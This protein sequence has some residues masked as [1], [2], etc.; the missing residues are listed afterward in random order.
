[1]VSNKVL[2]W[3]D[4]EVVASMSNPERQNYKICGEYELEVIV[5]VVFLLLCLLMVCNYSSELSCLQ[6]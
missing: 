6:L 1:M 2:Q 4:D 5:A 3:T